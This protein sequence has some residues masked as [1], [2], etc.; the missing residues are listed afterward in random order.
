MDRPSDRGVVPDCARRLD[1]L[2]HRCLAPHGGLEG[3][4]PL[5]TDPPQSVVAQQASPEASGPGR[6]VAKVCSNARLEAV[7]DDAPRMFARTWGLELQ[8]FLCARAI[9]IAG[10]AGS[11]PSSGI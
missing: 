11:A 10:G 5:N 1:D 3:C 8:W 2:V 4:Q 9:C 7:F 6:S